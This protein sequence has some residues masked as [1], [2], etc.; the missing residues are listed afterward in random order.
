MSREGDAAKELRSSQEQELRLLVET[1]P[2]LVGRAG[3]E[4]KVEF[5]AQLQAVL[6]LLPAYI[7][8]AAPSGALTFV[9]KK[10]AD[11]LSI[12]NDHPL[13]SG[14]DIGA[15]WD[16]WVPMLHPD[17]Q[18]ESRKYW[19]KSLR[20][21]EPG[22]HTYRV[23]SAQGEYRWFLSR[24]QPLRA[25]DGSVLLWVGATLDIEELKRAEQALRENEYKL[26]QIIEAV[27]GLVW[28]NGPDGEPTHVNQRMLDYAGMRFEDF[29]HGGW[30]RFVHPID[31]PDTARA[32]HQAIQTGT[33][34]EGVMRLRR[35]DGQFRWHQARCEPLVGGHGHIM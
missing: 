9:N 17:D 23:C 3:F 13:R 27:P 21:G 20:T 8:Y 5:T 31:Y 7:W 28:S 6:N 19:S 29:K 4:D 1:I 2:T 10:T 34:Y 35:V 12:P 30:E 15:R 33:A 14:I 25:S 18:E 32:F 16:D 24:Y 22:E 26:R 11:Y